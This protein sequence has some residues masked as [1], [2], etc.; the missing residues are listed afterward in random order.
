[1]YFCHLCGSPFTV[2]VHQHFAEAHDM[3][4]PVDNMNFV[5]IVMVNGNGTPRLKSP[6]DRSSGSLADLRTP[7][8]TSLS[9]SSPSSSPVLSPKSLRV[10][11]TVSHSKDLIPVKK[12]PQSTDSTAK[13]PSEDSAGNLLR[14]MEQLVKNAIDCS[15]ED[16]KDS[17]TENILPLPP[18]RN[19]SGFR[20][21]NGTKNS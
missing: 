3:H 13:I 9:G 5:Q 1:M 17:K 7:T 15:S 12:Y 10:A 8:P 16:R 11:Q 21:V 18:S 20:V 4:N 19:F 2:P 6:S 14:K